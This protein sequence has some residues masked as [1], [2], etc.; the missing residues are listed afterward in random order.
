MNIINIIP[1]PAL[2]PRV[3]KNGTYN[4]PAYTSYKNTLS[5]LIKQK[6]KILLLEPCS[7]TAVFY[8]PIPKMSRRKTLEHENCPHHKKPDL[9]NLI[10]ALKDSMTGIVFKDDSQV[11]C[12]NAKKVYSNNPRIE[13]LTRT[14][15]T[16]SNT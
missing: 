11:F 9:D 10:K 1:K 7:L 5:I 14:V 6:T 16:K 8:M 12:V 2:R 3:T 13:Y 15:V 4:P